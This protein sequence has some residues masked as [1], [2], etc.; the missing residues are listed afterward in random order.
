MIAGGFQPLEAYDLLLAPTFA[1]EPGAPRRAGDR[2][3][4][5][6]FGA[7][8]PQRASF[9]AEAAS[10]PLSAPSRRARRRGPTGGRRAAELEQ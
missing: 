6:C 1:P 8:L 3:G 10:D 7:E 2:L 5:G 4:R 9:T